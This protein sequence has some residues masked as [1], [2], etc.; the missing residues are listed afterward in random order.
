MVLAASL[1]AIYAAVR[2]VRDRRDLF[3]DAAVLAAVAVLVTL[4]LMVAS[5]VMFG[6]FDFIGPTF[7]AASY[8]NQPA[9]IRLFHSANWHWALMWRTCWF[10]LQSSSCS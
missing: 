8:L 3:R 10:L 5:E 7:S 2:L 1:V 6:R 4:V 9:Q